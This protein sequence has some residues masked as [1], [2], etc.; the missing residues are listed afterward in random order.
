M[1][2]DAPGE[3]ITAATYQAAFARIGQY[4]EQSSKYAHRVLSREPRLP[5]F[6]RSTSRATVTPML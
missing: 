4:F 2:P 6:A 3:V 1:I 5:K